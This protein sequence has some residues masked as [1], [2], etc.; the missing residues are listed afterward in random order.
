MANPKAKAS[1]AVTFSPSI[2]ISV[3][4]PAPTMRGSSQAQP[5]SAPASP[6]ELNRK[7][8]DAERARIR[9][10][11]ARAMTAP[12]PAATPLRA[13]MIG[14]GSSRMRWTTAP[15]IRVN[16]RTSRWSPPSS[17]RPMMS[18]TSPPEQKPRPSPWTTTTA[19]SSRCS[20]SVKTSRRS[21]YTSSVRAF[22]RS[23]RSKLTVATPPSTSKRKWRHCSVKGAEAR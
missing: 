4:R 23:G 5:M 17:R 7:R 1:S 6:T 18:P 21:A 3:A 11:A 14:F 12:A 16:S 10:S 2:R 9:K 15:V 19:T 20:S 8:N 13:A 22:S